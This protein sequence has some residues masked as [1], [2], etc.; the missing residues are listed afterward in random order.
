MANLLPPFIVD[1]SYLTTLSV[2]FSIY[3]WTTRL[4]SVVWYKLTWYF[5]ASST[6]SKYKINFSSSSFTETLVGVSNR[7]DLFW[8]FP[9]SP[10]PVVSA[11]PEI[12]NPSAIISTKNNILILFIF[13]TDCYYTKFHLF[14]Q[15]ITLLLT[16]NL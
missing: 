7:I 11:H 8:S 3:F 2:A 1:K 14:L 4:V 10:P 15:G 5:S 13:I 9:L 6:A 12:N 16:V